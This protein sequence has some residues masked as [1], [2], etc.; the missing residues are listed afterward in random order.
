[1][2]ANLIALEQMRLHDEIAVMET[3]LR[4]ISEGDRL[5]VLAQAMKNVTDHQITYTST[6]CSE[7]DI[8]L[9]LRPVEDRK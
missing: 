2:M 6:G 7:W 8:T 4:G 3:L 9:D 5:F 1:M